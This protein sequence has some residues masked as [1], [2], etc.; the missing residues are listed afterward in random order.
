MKVIN[1]VVF[2]P[3]KLQIT[4]FSSVFTVNVGIMCSMKENMA[5]VTSVNVKNLWSEEKVACDVS[6]SD[7]Q[8][9][10]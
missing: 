3:K 8:R 4:V 7:F 1:L 6:A 2:P 5:T 9:E 10:K